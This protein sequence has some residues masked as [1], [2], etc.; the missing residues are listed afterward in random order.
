MAASTYTKGKICIFSYNSRGF[1]NEKQDLCNLL[2]THTEDYYP[3]LCN[4]QNFLLQGNRYLA[5]KCLP[6]ARL[7]FKNA[8]KD[9]F[10]GRPKNGMFIAIPDVIKQQVNN[11]S[12]AHWMEVPGYYSIDLRIL[13]IN[14]YFPTDP[15][16]A[17]SDTSDLHSTLSATN[18]VIEDNEFDKLIWTGDINADFIR[19]SMFTGII[20]D[21]ISNRSMIKSWDRYSVDFTHTFEMNVHW[22]SS[23]LDHFFWSENI[24]ED[25]IEASVLPMPGNTSDHCPIYCEMNTT[26]LQTTS[27]QECKTSRKINWNKASEEERAA[28]RTNLEHLLKSIQSPAGIRHCQNSHCS[29]K[30]HLSDC[31]NILYDILQSINHSA[32]KCFPVTQSGGKMKHGI[33]KWRGEIVPFRDKAL[34]WHSVWQSAGRPL[35]TD[36]HKIMEKNRNLYHFQIRK[37]K[38]MTEILKRNTL[39]DA[40]INNNG[41]IFDIIRKQRQTTPSVP[42]M[43]DGISVDMETYFARLYGEL[44]DSVKDRDRLISVKQFLSKIVDPS[45]LKDIVKI[46]PE[47]LSQ[48]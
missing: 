24:I 22:Y 37:N 39:L 4:Q 9:N 34:F 8:V 44:Y 5:K 17:T 6:D 45:N 11:A 43:I 38:K 1:S 26:G 18:S 3:I 16:T 10:E 32:I 12:P 47:R 40:C 21:F 48:E 2:M 46:T 35:N 13:L 28:Y 33:T 31:D 14:S 42:G 23:T 36:F 7:V 30:I 41:N 15:K 19:N 20:D 25:A 29:D 27:Q